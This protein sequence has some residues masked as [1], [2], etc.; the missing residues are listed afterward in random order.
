MADFLLAQDNV[1][2]GDTLT[3][4]TAKQQIPPDGRIRLAARF[5]QHDHGSDCHAGCEGNAI[6]NGGVG[7]PDRA[8]HDGPR[9]P[10][11][12]LTK[13]HAR[14][15]D[16]RRNGGES[17][18]TECGRARGPGSRLGRKAVIGAVA[19]AVFA[20]VGLTGAQAA[21]ASAV[22]QPAPGAHTFT[23]TGDWDG[24]HKQDI[25][26]GDA[27]GDWWVYPGASIRGPSGQQPVKIAQGYFGTTFAGMGDWDGDHRDDIIF[28]RSNGDLMVYP[29]G[30]VRGPSGREPSVIGWGWNG[31]TFAGVGDWDRDGHDD[32]MFRRDA[33]YG[34]T[35]GQLRVYFGRG[36][37]GYSPQPDTTL[38]QAG[39]GGVTFVGLG[40]WDSDG[41]QDIVYRTD[42]VYGANAGQVRVY[43][44]NGTRQVIS[45]S[46]VPVGWG[47]TPYTFVAVGDW[48][49]DHHDDIAYRTS[50]GD[51]LLYAGDGTR[52]A[53]WQK[54]ELI[55]QG[56]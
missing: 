13:G 4:Q 18:P 48:D 23:G 16:R 9:G 8:H 40:D 45:G 10:G 26:L 33:A 30:S 53:N 34:A 24:D 5:I 52:G 6:A 36:A 39:W 27:A 46:A 29:G 37:P 56:W 2:I 7:R 31:I 42:T 20:A 44:G 14:W 35:S 21:A 3:A 51:L 50:G 47:W 38:L 1:V 43:F 49:G 28:R 55:A 22:A 17:H 15:F 32:V 41:R 11:G 54:H 25:V 12:R 19:A